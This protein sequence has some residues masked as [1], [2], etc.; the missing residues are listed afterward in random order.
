MCAQYVESLNTEEPV[1]LQNDEP[2][3]VA[4][5]LAQLFADGTLPIPPL[6]SACL[7]A[8][9]P[10]GPWLFATHDELGNLNFL[11]PASL[12]LLA[13]KGNGASGLDDPTAFLVCGVE[14]HGVN[15]WYFQYIYAHSRLCMGISLPYGNAYA[16]A[17][18]ADEQSAETKR[19]SAA[20]DMLELCLHSTRGGQY[21]G[22]YEN[23]QLLWGVCMVHGQESVFFRL[24]DPEGQVLLEGEGMETL[25]DFLQSCASSGDTAA[26]SQWLRA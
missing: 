18:A 12:K 15:S 7:P 2:E 23:A 16:E 9:Q 19:L 6:P 3:Y 26:S 13:D 8:L 14:G 17:D 25:L 24:C 4:H 22:T 20:R 11:S 21:F 10:V 1:T 5:D